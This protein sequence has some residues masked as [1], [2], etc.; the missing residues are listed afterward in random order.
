MSQ[1]GLRHVGSS[2]LALLLALFAA[3]ASAQLA[4]SADRWEAEIGQFETA[5]VAHPPKPDGIVF[6]GSSSIRLWT[7]L[8]GDF[9]NRNTLNRGFGGSKIADSTRYAQR[10]VT[11]YRPRLVVLYAG[12]NDIAEGAS[13]AQVLVDFRDF[14]AAVRKDM[15]QRPI[16]FIS[17]KPSPSR[18]SL[19]PTMRA[20]N[21]LVSDYAR[22]QKN[23]TYVDVFAPMLDSSGQPRAELFI[24]DG[25]HMNRAGYAL[26]ASILAPRLEQK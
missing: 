7:T 20:A 17:I 5:D 4:P 23:I 13:A 15:P 19:M 11:N 24:A 25:L 10:I 26:W 3:H 1:H 8:A 12:D 21:A 14:V 18:A 9:P 16:V 22:T 6:V 2:A